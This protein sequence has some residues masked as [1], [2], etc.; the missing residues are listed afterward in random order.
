MARP[1]DYEIRKLNNYIFLKSN[2]TAHLI[3]LFSYFIFY[4]INCS[5]IYYMLFKI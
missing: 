2:M 3:R 5:S 4:E 1:V